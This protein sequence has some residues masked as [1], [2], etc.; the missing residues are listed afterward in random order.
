MIIP[1]RCF[2]CGKVIGNKWET[3]LSLLQ[4]DFSE[5]DALDELG[6][7]RYCCRRMMLT[8][9]DLIEKLLNYNTES[10]EATEANFGDELCCEILPV[11]KKSK[12]K[13][14]LA[15]LESEILLI[16][17]CLIFCAGVKQ[18]GGHSSRD[19]NRVSEM[20][21]NKKMK[22]L[23]SKE[24]FELVKKYL[25]ECPHVPPDHPAI[26]AA[27]TA[28]DKEFNARERDRKLQMKFSQ[29]KTQKMPGQSADKL[30]DS[31]V[32]VDRT[33]SS[34]PP[35]T[36]QRQDSADDDMEWQDVEEKEKEASGDE[37]SY[38]GKLLAKAAVDAIFEHKAKAK[39][40]VQAIAL[41]F[42]AALRSD[43][44]GFQCTGLPEATTKGGFAPPVRELPKSQFLPANWDAS[45]NQVALRYRKPGTNALVLR[46][47]EGDD[48]QIIVCLEPASNKEPSSQN[49]TFSLG[50]HI[51]MDS[52][53]AA[54]KN[55]P[56]V[57]PTLHY[58]SLASLLTNFCR[59][60]DLGP[61]NEG[62][63][64]QEVNAALYVDNN[65]PQ[66]KSEFIPARPMAVP[67]VG[68]SS[69]RPDYRTQV[70]S[71][72]GEAFPGMNPLRVGGDFS[73]DLAPAGIGDLRFPS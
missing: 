16:I 39:T 55:A 64:P 19:P 62:I 61:V 73:G 45:K 9:V 22:T 46:V 12:K 35:T 49:L 53:N 60:F 32:V 5:G 68:G 34:S 63:S 25:M 3:Y 51:N 1:V 14:K 54:L 47:E 2:T 33:S 23:E 20:S 7:K 6:L 27:V 37:T 67:P 59:T 65:L 57:A 72:L 50:D 36:A 40:P 56:A 48:Q 42:H 17:L 26:K 11:W 8:H 71:T 43:H 70:P 58:K 24:E 21:N 28:I 69:M 44:L 29:S 18:D 13:D 52:W 66:S 4:A 38:L 41:I 15:S 30:D 31:V 10:A